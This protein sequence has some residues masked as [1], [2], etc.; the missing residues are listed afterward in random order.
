MKKLLMF[1]SVVLFSGCSGPKI[2]P[3][4]AVP[5]A[6][7]VTY[8][9]P[10]DATKDF[11]HIGGVQLRNANLSH[12]VDHPRNF[13]E[14]VVDDDIIVRSISG[15]FKENRSTTRKKGNRT[16][17]VVGSSITYK[18]VVTETAGQGFTDYLLRPATVETME[19]TFDI[20]K[21]SPDDAADLLAQ[22]LVNVIFE[23]D[24]TYAT[25]AI[26]ANFSRILKPFNKQPVQIGP[27]TYSKGYNINL[28]N[29]ATAEVYVEVSPYRSGS[30]TSVNAYLP[31]VADNRRFIDGV[32]QVKMLKKRITD[33]VNN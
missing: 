17:K 32:A 30:K 21:F 13:R 10:I 28:A 20:P 33:I 4:A 2:I 26:Y 31:L 23:V 1:I 9:V 6:P 19:N 24:S 3:P 16:D 25:E 18:V 11:G 22:G 15:Q 14:I 5:D 7:S 8:R 12:D 29:N 27:G